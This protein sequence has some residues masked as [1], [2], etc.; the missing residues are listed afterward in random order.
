MPRTWPKHGPANHVIGI[1]G[2]LVDQKLRLHIKPRTRKL[3]RFADLL[4]WYWL[5]VK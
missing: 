4:Y 2:F 3:H 1:G 5:I